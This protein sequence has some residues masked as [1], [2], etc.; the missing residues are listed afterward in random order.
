MQLKKRFTFATSDELSD[1][2]DHGLDRQRPP[3]SRSSCGLGRMMPSRR[4]RRPITLLGAGHRRMTRC[5]VPSSSRHAIH[6]P[7]KRELSEHCWHSSVGFF[8]TQQRYCCDPTRTSGQ[9]G[10]GAYLTL[11]DERSPTVTGRSGG[12]ACPDIRWDARLRE[13]CS[14]LGDGVDALVAVDAAAERHPLQVNTTNRADY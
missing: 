2:R 1:L 8:P 11:N 7:A 6:R 5:L 12:R 4:R 10:A 3:T 14:L 13:R 9:R